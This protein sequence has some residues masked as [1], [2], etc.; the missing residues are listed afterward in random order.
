[1]DSYFQYSVFE[2]TVLPRRPSTIYNLQPHNEPSGNKQQDE[3]G[4]EFDELLQNEE[5]RTI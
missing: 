4:G 1:M 5:H 2:E 3:L